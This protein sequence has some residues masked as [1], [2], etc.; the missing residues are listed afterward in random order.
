[1]VQE[2]QQVVWQR[3]NQKLPWM[4]GIPSIITS[5][6]QMGDCSS[7]WHPSAS[8]V[9]IC[10]ASGLTHSGSP[11]SNLLQ[12]SI[13]RQLVHHLT[14]MTLWRR[15]GKKWCQ[16]Q[17]C[18]FNTKVVPWRIG[19]LVASLKVQESTYCDD[20][21]SIFLR[22]RQNFNVSACPCCIFYISY[23]VLSMQ[24]LCPNRN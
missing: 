22:C 21:V 14:P 16:K 24:L 12:P 18:F 23:S 17:N 2:C 9:P 4:A 11:P 15:F 7:P 3:R 19:R 10:P 6:I 13:L 5:C 20:W 1:M 8:H